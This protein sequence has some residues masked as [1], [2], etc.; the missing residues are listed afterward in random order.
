MGN[1]GSVHDKRYEFR[2]KF[3]QV[4]RRRRQEKGLSQEQLA[5]RC[6]LHRT[7]ISEVER[8]LKAV[9]LMSLLRIAKALD[10]PAYLLVKEA[11]YPEAGRQ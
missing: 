5:D 1:A 10:I 8:G 4:V 3:G 9:S 6:N 2:L 7:Y 11:E